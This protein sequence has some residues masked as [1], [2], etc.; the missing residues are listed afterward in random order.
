M[1]ILKGFRSQASLDLLIS[2]GVAILV[3]SIAL[4]VVLQLG[5]FNMRL[6]PSYCNAAPNFVC[7]AVAINNSG[8]MTLVFSQATGGTLNISA[9]ACSTEANTTNAG[10]AY[11]NFGML[12]YTVAPTFYPNNQLQNN[13]LVYSSNQTRIFVNC[14]SGA[15]LAKGSLGTTFSGFVWIKYTINTLPNSYNAVEQIASM[16]TKYT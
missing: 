11:G 12:P 15:G 8:A 7:A 16:S 1:E 14:Y 6:A 10:P 4:Y 5:I 3:I 2:Y 13:L 9:V